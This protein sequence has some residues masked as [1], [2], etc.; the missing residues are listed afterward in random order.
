MIAAATHFR[1]LY[2]IVLSADGNHSLQKKTKKDDSNDISL[3]KGH[4][5]F[6]DPATMATM[7][8]ASYAKDEETK[9]VSNMLE[10]CM[11]THN[12]QLETCSGF[13]V[14]CSQCPGKFR[15]LDV[16]GVVAVTC[17]HVFFRNGAVVDL[18]TGEQYVVSLCRQSPCTD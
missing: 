16:S 8:V 4:S 2:R 17:R 3:S 10:M 7:A 11:Y 1:F 13:K 15:F 6:V 12:T 9:P 5:F 18:I 14:T